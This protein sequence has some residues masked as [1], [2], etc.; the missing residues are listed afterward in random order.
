MIAAFLIIVL[1]QLACEALPN[2]MTLSL[3]YLLALPQVVDANKCFEK[4]PPSALSLQLASY[5]Y[6]LQIYAHLAPCFKDKC[7]PLYRVS[8]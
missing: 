3:A 2:D 5:Y 6:S 8:F 1:L 4:Q 7:H